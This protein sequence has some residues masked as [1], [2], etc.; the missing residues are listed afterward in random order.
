MLFASRAGEVHDLHLFSEENVP[1]RS[2]GE[3]YPVVDSSNYIKGK[4]SFSPIGNR[5]YSFGDGSEEAVF[6]G[7]GSPVSAKEVFP[8][9]ERYHQEWSKFPKCTM[10]LVGPNKSIFA[11]GNPDAPLTVYIS[12][13]AGMTNPEVDSPYSTSYTDQNPGSLSSVDI[14]MSDARKITA[15]SVKMDTVVVH[16]DKG[17]HLL[18]APE[19]D[20]A[21]TGYRTKQA[22]S[23][24]FS[25]AVNNQVVRG[26]KDQKYW[27]GHDKQIYKDESAT[28]SAEGAQEMADRDQASAKAKGEWELGLPEDLS[29]S[30]STYNAE[31][32]MYWV[33]VESQEYKDFYAKGRPGKIY[34]LHINRNLTLPDLIPQTALNLASIIVDTPAEMDLDIGI[35]TIDEPGS[36]TINVDIVTGDPLP[37][38]PGSP[39][40]FSIQSIKSDK[41]ST[42][43][44][45][46]VLE[47]I[48]SK[49]HSP[50]IG[51]E[52]IKSDK[53]AVIGISRGVIVPDEP[54]SVNIKLLDVEA[55]DPDDPVM[56]VLEI[57]S[58]EPHSPV[59]NSEVLTPGIP[60][61]TM[62]I[63]EPDE[64]LVNN[65]QVTLI[66]S[67]VPGPA[68]LDA[69]L[70]SP[71]IPAITVGIVKP[72]EPGI[73]PWFTL[74]Q[75]APLE[76]VG[77][78]VDQT[79]GII[80]DTVGFVFI[81]QFEP[82]TIISDEPHP[83][84]LTATAIPDEE[85]PP[86]APTALGLVEQTDD[87]YPI[88]SDPP[89]ET[90]GLS[91]T[92]VFDST[93]L[94]ELADY[95][96]GKY[97]KT[98]GI[99]YD[100]TERANEESP[101]TQLFA[102][103]AGTWLYGQSEQTSYPAWSG[104]C[105]E[106]ELDEIP[107]L[108][109]E[110]AADAVDSS[111][112]W[113]NSVTV[114]HHKQRAIIQGFTM[115]T[116]YCYSVWSELQYVGLRD[117][118][119]F[120]SSADNSGIWHN[121]VV[122][123]GKP[124]WSWNIQSADGG[125]TQSRSGHLLAGSDG[126]YH[127]VMC[128]SSYDID[129]AR[130]GGV[131]NDLKYRVEKTFDLDDSCTPWGQTSVANINIRE[132]K[133]YIGTKAIRG[134]VCS[135][136]GYTKFDKFPELVL[137]PGQESHCDDAWVPDTGTPPG[138]GGSPGNEPGGG[139]PEEPP[140]PEG[141]SLDAVLEAAGDDQ[142]E[143]TMKNYPGVR[144][145]GNSSDYDYIGMHKINKASLEQAAINFSGL[146]DHYA[147]LTEI[148]EICESWSANLYWG[149]TS[150]IGQGV[151][152][153]GAWG[154]Y[155][156]GSDDFVINTTCLTSS[157]AL[158]GAR[159]LEVMRHEA[160][161]AGQD[162]L[163]EKWMELTFNGNVPAFI[164]TPLIQIGNMNTDPF[165]IEEG[166][167][168]HTIYGLDRIADPNDYKDQSGID[169]VAEL[170]IGGS[171]EDYFDPS[172]A[173]VELESNSIEDDEALSRRARL[174]VANKNNRQDDIHPPFSTSVGLPLGK[175]WMIDTS[176]L[177]L[178]EVEKGGG[179]FSVTDQRIVVKDEDTIAFF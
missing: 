159:A 55:D 103:S 133:Y 84:V 25:S 9:L 157:G 20:Q 29:Q 2:L 145:A 65:L 64:V 113:P 136:D 123:T 11:T 127:V 1:L 107:D 92:R 16:T 150:D 117:Y 71:G 59:L 105:V 165:E 100:S 19:G 50:I 167:T 30:F 51:I 42:V 43:H 18:Y 128:T 81:F 56:Q 27:L 154:W 28:R 176:T 149:H 134:G 166:Q 131:N 178:T 153:H 78:G 67:T 54:H 85:I 69:D 23:G 146:R 21:A 129:E 41:P 141:G 115:A 155:A 47:I 63:I 175:T 33:Y 48:S 90:G 57:V 137:M 8:D 171:T 162:R 106:D 79:K 170:Y 3:N 82:G 7:L 164:P 95:I 37:F 102:T 86:G 35:V 34:G 118:D 88:L 76:I 72:D 13:P 31:G 101:K 160:I 174:E 91:A 173:I 98:H 68:V 5:L 177:K 158:N 119:A 110:S 87:S 77:F 74:E 70:V 6:V 10:F 53:P 148:L 38:D 126:K 168:W 114:R 4:S 139:D 96:P 121:F 12:E 172:I 73:V 116:R 112:Y 169:Q 104:I 135:P 99:E 142:W 66:R 97:L 163:G 132:E 61:L 140:E 22:P 58:D 62:G 44:H 125:R 156:S 179:I 24:V 52:T 60:V 108:S 94:T 109:T 161:H 80:S 40:R 83:P 46:E 111:F 89:G 93:C 45:I 36:P 144:W 39:K 124:S 32:G 122:G 152:S 14:L 17:C 147:E 151:F 138:G 120:V 49:T 143:T 26:E 15:L 130:T 75:P